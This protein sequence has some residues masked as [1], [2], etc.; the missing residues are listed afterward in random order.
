M[1]DSDLFTND[2]GITFRVIRRFMGHMQHAAILNISTGAN[3][4][5]IH[6]STNSN[7]RPDT[8]IITQ[9]DIANDHATAVD[10]DAIAL[11]WE[12]IFIGTEYCRHIN[13]E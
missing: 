5:V 9:P 10:H 12:K 7:Q 6:I 3:G 11:F 1:T 2:Q 4:D 8:D 13:L